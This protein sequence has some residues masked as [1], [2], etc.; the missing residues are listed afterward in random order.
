MDMMH[1]LVLQFRLRRPAIWL[2]CRRGKALFFTW[3]DNSINETGFTIQRA[4]DPVFTT[5]LTTFALTECDDLYRYYQEQSGVL[6]QSVRQH[7]VGDTGYI[8][9]L[10]SAS[11]PWR[12]TLRSLNMAQN[13]NPS[14]G[15]SGRSDCA[16]RHSSKRAAG[17]PDVD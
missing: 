2:S 17:C 1:S 8:P 9:H 13:R 11:P 14:G 15:N 12:P 7:V 3:V 6:L 10:R 4:A 16:A 5:G